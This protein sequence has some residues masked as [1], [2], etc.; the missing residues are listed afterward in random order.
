[1]F[2]IS[3]LVIM[4]IGFIL[5]LF[6]VS[7]GI[8]SFIYF[9]HDLNRTLEERQVEIFEVDNIKVFNAY[10]YNPLHIEVEFSQDFA[11]EYVLMYG[12]Y[13]FDFY[14]E[15]IHMLVFDKNLIITISDSGIASVNQY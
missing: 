6:M 7:F 4:W 2:R 12:Y 9:S 13:Y 10:G 14:Q 3:Y 5:F 1:M 11:I 8:Y 15:N